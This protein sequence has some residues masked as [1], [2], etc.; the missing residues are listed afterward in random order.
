MS[1]VRIRLECVLFLMINSPIL[2]DHRF[3]GLCFVFFPF[4]VHKKNNKNPENRLISDDSHESDIVMGGSEGTDLMTSRKSELSSVHSICCGRGW[5][6]RKSVAALAS[7]RS[8]AI[9][10]SNVAIRG[11]KGHESLVFFCCMSSCQSDMAYSGTLFMTRRISSNCSGG[12]MCS[13]SCSR[14]KMAAR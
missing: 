4:D 6:R 12:R 9:H 2:R 1:H 5:V 11:S 13:C 14:M 10:L 3:L 7:S 8:S